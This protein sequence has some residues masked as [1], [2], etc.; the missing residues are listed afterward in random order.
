MTILFSVKKR[1]PDEQMND[2]TTSQQRSWSFHPI[3]DHTRQTRSDPRER[4]DD[5]PPF[6]FQFIRTVT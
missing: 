5:T 1:P 3:A 2:H 4:G 6:W